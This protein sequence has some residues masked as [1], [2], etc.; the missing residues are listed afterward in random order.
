MSE[1]I[2]TVDHLTD[3]YYVYRAPGNP[4]DACD[5]YYGMT[6][7]RTDAPPYCS[8]NSLRSVLLASRMHRVKLKPI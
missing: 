2:G 5:W 8:F 3:R 6:K 1:L 7:G 4:G